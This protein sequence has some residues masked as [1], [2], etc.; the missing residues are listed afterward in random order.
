MESRSWYQADQELAKILEEEKRQH[1]MEREL[2]TGNRHER[3]AMK[4][5]QR[6]AA[7]TKQ[8]KVGA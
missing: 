8:R 3:R 6:K 4:A 2:A 5:L 7:F 1:D